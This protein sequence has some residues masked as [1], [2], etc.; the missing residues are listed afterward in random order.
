M[1]KE[2]ELKKAIFMHLMENKMVAFQF[3]TLCIEPDIQHLAREV[4]KQKF[5]DQVCLILKCCGSRHFC[6][7]VSPSDVMLY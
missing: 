2:E 7:K 1:S 4:V 5:T 3:R 6:L